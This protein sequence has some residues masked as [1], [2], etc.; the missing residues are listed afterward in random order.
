MEADLIELAGMLFCVWVSGYSM[1]FVIC[2]FR[3]FLEKI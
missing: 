2:Y 1:G 3:K